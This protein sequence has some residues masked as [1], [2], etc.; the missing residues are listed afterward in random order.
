MKKIIACFLLI[1]LLAGCGEKK[2]TAVNLSGISFDADITYGKQKCVCSIEIQG[3]GM[4]KMELYEPE[5]LKGTI[6]TYDGD[7]VLLNYHGLEYTPELPITNETLGEI[8]NKILS[9]VS[10]GYREAERTEKGFV[11]KGKVSDYSYELYVSEAGL[12]L[13]LFCEEAN[14]YAEFS[15]AKIQN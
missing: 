1:F 12:P 11:L 8:I 2:T 5:N 6:I 10:S 13:S 9:T 3:A 4:L 14:L 15:N 7:T